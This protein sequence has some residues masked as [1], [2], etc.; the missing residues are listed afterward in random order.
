MPAP[1]P[2][3]RRSCRT[4]EGLAAPS[5]PCRR[6]RRVGSLIP[7]GLRPPHL[8]GWDGSGAR[9]NCRS[10]MMAAAGNAVAWPWYPIA[11]GGRSS[12]PGGGK[13]GQRGSRHVVDGP[14]RLSPTSSACHPRACHQTSPPRCGQTD[15]DSPPTVGPSPSPSPSI[16]GRRAILHR[17]GTGG[18]VS[19]LREPAAAVP[20]VAG[21]GRG[22]R[23]G[24]RG[25]G[26]SPRHA[27]TERR[28]GGPWR[29]S[30][31]PGCHRPGAEEGAPARRTP[32]AL[33]RSGGLP[34]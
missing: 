12:R 30:T 31:P 2:L 10:R 14:L 32:L 25:R 1:R 6:D 33:N 34:R 13:R 20:V 16:S 18:A 9:S 7:P 15:R 17:L 8:C 28:G 26:V 4:S 23:R 19:G 5:T 21:R 29:A 22:P 27:P 11:G 3:P 24:G